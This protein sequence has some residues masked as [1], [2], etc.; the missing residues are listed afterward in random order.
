MANT[1][2]QKFLIKNVYETAKSDSTSGA[3]YAYTFSCADGSETYTI[4]GKASLISFTFSSFYDDDLLP[5]PLKIFCVIQVEGVMIVISN[6]KR[7]SYL[8]P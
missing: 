2:Y 3:G 4:G 6:M 1:C 7:V 8:Y 5:L